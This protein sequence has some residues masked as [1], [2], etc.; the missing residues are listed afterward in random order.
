MLRVFTDPKQTCFAT[1]DITSLY[2]ET[3]TQ[4]YPIRN[5]SYAHI[6]CTF[7]HFYEKLST[8]NVNYYLT[9]NE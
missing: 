1:N 7:E 4:F 9:I 2:G 5:Q 3:P 6:S 8:R